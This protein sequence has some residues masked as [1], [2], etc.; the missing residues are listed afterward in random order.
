M[1]QALRQLLKAPGYTLAAVTTLALAIGASTAIFSAVYAVL[2]KPMPIRAQKQ[3]V[4]GWGLNPARAGVVEL[5]YLEIDDLVK[6]TPGIGEVAGVGSSTWTAV[7]GGEG[8]PLKLAS[9]GVTGNFFEVLGTPPALG[10][11]LRREDDVA[12][13]PR[14]VVISHALWVRQFGSDTSIVGRRIELDDERVEIVGVAP[15]GFNY[16]Y[17]TDVWLPVLPVLVAS[18]FKEPLRSAGVLFMVARLNPGITAALA[19]ERWTHANARLQLTSLAPKYDLIATPFT[20]HHI[21]PARQVLWVVFGAVGVLLLVACANIS[22]LML[23]RVA[24]RQHDHAVRMAIGASRAAVQ[25]QW[26]REAAVLAGLGGAAG[27]LVSYWLMSAIVALAP[28][29]IPRLG[30]ISINVPVAA[31]SIVVMSVAM[32][33]C[34]MA[35]M[36][37]SSAINLLEALNDANRTTAGARSYRMRSLLLV[38]QIAMCVV[39]LVAAGLVVKSF[40]RLRDIALGF[41]PAGVLTLKV[42][43]RVE[44]PAAN[45][46]MR[47]LIERIG[48]LPFTGSVGAVSLLPLELGAIGQGAMVLKEGQPQTV[49]A[50]RLNPVLNYQV[51][52]PG[53]FEAMGISLKRGRVFDERDTA[54]SERVAII[55]ERTAALMFPGEDPLGRRLRMATFLPEGGLATRTI[56]GVVGDVRYRGLHEVLPDVYDPASQSPLDA[57]SLAVRIRSGDG[58]DPLAAASAVQQHA[59]ELDPRAIV[60]RLTTLETVVSTAMAP[61]RLSA[62]VFA[63]FA[64]L[65]LLLSTVGLFSLVSLDVASRRRELAVRSALGAT[66]TTI[67]RGVF[68]VAARRVLVGVIA[69]LAVALAASRAIRGLLFEVE[70]IDAPT[71]AAVIGLVAAVT[72]VAAYVPARRAASASPLALLRRE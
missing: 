3:L 61:W 7:L 15:A 10:R 2:L 50:A 17:G 47:S 23:T 60:S 20:E 16:P 19:A 45:E 32:L 65:A 39:L 33:L 38:A 49:D 63:V 27:V 12:G 43:P 62:W 5:A 8:E 57:L 58:T 36:R 24:A 35:P 9:A 46:W 25:G 55:S 52:T 69:G 41:E 51:A 54:T 11:L 67:V 6:A 68:T 71:Y 30:D 13:A 21:G 66:A 40:D 4:V 56:V 26:A 31:F 28:D 70:A 48:E 22:G 34:G 59:R 64:G 29:G 42:E 14:V 18:P 72:A 37:H 53:Y 1:R 44:R